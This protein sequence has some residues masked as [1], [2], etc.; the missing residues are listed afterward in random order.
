[1]ALRDAKV[2]GVGD[3]RSVAGRWLRALFFEDWGL[4][5]LAMAITLG[6]W[7]AVAG[8]RAPATVRL[9]GV[10]LEFVRP[11][12]IEISDE[13][14][15]DV[16]ITLEGSQGK[17]A[18]INARNLIARADITSLRPGDRVARLTRQNVSMELPDGVQIVRIEPGS[19][20]LRLEF[21][22]EVEVKVEAR[23]EGN[24]PEGYERGQV[25]INPPRV[26]VRGPESHVD[27][28]EMAQTE[29]I[30]LEGQKESLTLPQIA[31]DIPDRK[32]VPLEPVVAVRVEIIEEQAEKRFSN[33]PVQSATGGH[34]QPQSV[35]I[36]VRGP[37]SIIKNLRPEDV[38]ISLEEGADGRFTPRLSL[39]PNLSGRV[40]LVS[41][42][43]S[44]FSVS[45]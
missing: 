24:L 27:A 40:E 8:Q 10:Q 6:L 44:E 45:R 29:T 22:K 19:V 26:R 25:Q 7:Y 41:V 39:P 3:A 17:L 15:E 35:Q 20:A 14:V 34:P 32:V 16:D 36:L 31:I 12:D 2:K 23:F 28:V 18:E 11:H 13:P 42:S 38:R 21:I 43:P 37:R 4:K 33:V 5:L 30:S 1:M 9:R